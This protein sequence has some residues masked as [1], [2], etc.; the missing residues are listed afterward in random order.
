M[1]ASKMPKSVG[2]RPAALLVAESDARLREALAPAADVLKQALMSQGY[3]V[4]VAVS[5]EEARHLLKQRSFDKIYGERASLLD[6][7]PALPGPRVEDRDD[8]TARVQIDQIVPWSTAVELLDILL[9]DTAP[10]GPRR[11]S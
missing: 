11:R 1:A 6:P 2:A 9:A 4:V 10:S 7:V 3:E 8:G 5:S